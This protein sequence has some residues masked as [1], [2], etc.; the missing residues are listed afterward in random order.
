M[1]KT[2]KN[3]VR[4]LTHSA[5]L[6]CLGCQSLDIGKKFDANWYFTDQ[7]ETKQS[8]VLQCIDPSKQKGADLK[9]VGLTHACLS[10]DDVKKLAEKL[11]NCHA[12]DKHLNK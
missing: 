6:F 8:T 3:Y 9:N 2:Q 11:N 12:L 10:M 1:K 5:F 4:F 7:T